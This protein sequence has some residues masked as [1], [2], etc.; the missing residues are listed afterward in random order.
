[1]LRQFSSDIADVA[2]FRL[3]GTIGNVTDTFFADNP[4]AMAIAMAGFRIRDV[5]LSVDK[6]GLWQRILVQKA[7][8]TGKSLEQVRSEK[9]FSVHDSLS[10]TSQDNSQ[11]VRLLAPVFDY[12]NAGGFLTV[13][14]VAKNPKGVGVYEFMFDPADPYRWLEYFNLKATRQEKETDRKG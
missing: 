14:A 13:D 4:V 2:S 9:I 1:M 5:Y 11:T 12:L 3:G 10:K 6:D 8:Q 7:E